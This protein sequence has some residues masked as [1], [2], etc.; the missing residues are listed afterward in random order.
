[1]MQYITPDTIGYTLLI[2]GMLV[3]ERY[4]AK[5]TRRTKK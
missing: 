2:V 5:P 3:C 1:M 4:I